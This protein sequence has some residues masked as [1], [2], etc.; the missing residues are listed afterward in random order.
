M[1]TCTDEDDETLVS[2][3]FLLIDPC[4]LDNHEETENAMTENAMTVSGE[5]VRR[6]KIFLHDAFGHRNSYDDLCG[7]AKMIP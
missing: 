5:N 2:F 7:G 1:K 3:V 6:K 4:D